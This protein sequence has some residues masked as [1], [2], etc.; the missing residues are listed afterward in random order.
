MEKSKQTFAKVRIE[1][2]KKKKHFGHR[3]H[4]K[5]SFVFVSS[6][7]QNIPQQFSAFLWLSLQFSAQFNSLHQQKMSPA[8]QNIRHIWFTSCRRV[9]S[10]S[11]HLLTAVELCQ[12]RF[13]WSTPEC[14][15][16]VF[17]HA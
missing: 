16:E 6:N 9:N 7:L 5:F 15:C 2:I 3:I 17:Q 10:G 11:N 14:D 1:I 8:N 4:C 12:D 13:F